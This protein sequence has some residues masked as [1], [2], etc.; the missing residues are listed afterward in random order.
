MAKPR[1]NFDAALINDLRSRVI[2]HNTRSGV[3]PVKLG[4]L[5]HVYA[6]SYSGA[7]AGAAAMGAVEGFLAKAAGD[8][9][10]AEH[11]R[12]NDGKFAGRG[13]RASARINTTFP[14][15]HDDHTALAASNAGYRALQSG[16]IPENRGETTGAIARQLGSG[17]AGLT[18]AV[19]LARGKPNGIAASLL[20]RKLAP[21]G[22]LAGAAIGTAAGIVEQR[23]GDLIHKIPGMAETSAD[24]AARTA[25]AN[26][27]SLQASIVGAK[28]ARRVGITTYRVASSGMRHWMDIASVGASTPLR[29]R[30]RRVGAV[31]LAA[32]PVVSLINHE[33][34]GSQVDPERLGSAF[35]AY[36]VRHVLKSVMTD[37]IGTA[38]NDLVDLLRKGISADELFKAVPALSG[39]Y[40]AAG[41]AV[42]TGLGA[43]SGGLAGAGLGHGTQVVARHIAGKRGNPYHDGR[44]RFTHA[45]GAGALAGGVA[46]AVAAGLA[47]YAGLRTH[48]IGQLRA[49]AK[50]AL[51]IN[52]RRMAALSNPKG[53]G[54][55]FQKLLAQRTNMIDEAVAAHPSVKAAKDSVEQFG[56]SS[57]LHYKT[58]ILRHSNERIAS[59]A[60]FL[61]NFEVPVTKSGQTT[62]RRIADIKAGASR[63]ERDQKAAD[64]IIDFVET[65]SPADFAR[66]IK[67]VSVENQTTLR[68]F[69]DNQTTW[70]NG[71]DQ[72]IAAHHA[73]IAAAQQN[74]EA[75]ATAHLAA[76]A[77]ELDA[78]AV[79]GRTTKEDE[80]AVKKTEAAMAK[81]GKES[82]KARKAHEKAV[83][84]LD[85]LKNGS[86]K[87]IS[88]ITG[89]PLAQPTPMDTRA[90]IQNAEN[91]V[92]AV[93][94]RKVD[95]EIAAFRT[96][97]RRAAVERHNRILAA[98]AVIGD[99]HGLPEAARSRGAVVA[100][101]ERQIRQ[102]RARV[103]DA[104]NALD[105]AQAAL[106]GIGKRPKAD[107]LKQLRNVVQA[108]A[109]RVAGAQADL[110]VSKSRIAPLTANFVKHLEDRAAGNTNRLIPAGL[111]GD[112]IRDLG[113]ATATMKGAARDFLAQPTM[114]GLLNFAASTYRTVHNAVTDTAHQLFFQETS[115]GWKPSWVRI[116]TSSALV[117]PTI[118]G[119]KDLYD[120]GRAAIAGDPAAKFPHHIIEYD[121]DPNTGAAYAAVVVPHPK[122]KGEKVVL[123]GQR[124]DSFNGQARQI[125]AGGRISTVKENYKKRNDKNNDAGDATGRVHNGDADAMSDETKKAIGESLGKLRGANSIIYADITN[126]PRVAY[127]SSKDQD[128]NESAG[129][130]LQYMRDRFLNKGSLDQGQYWKALTALSSKQA[131]IFSPKQS[132]EA[133]TNTKPDGGEGRYKNG[134]FTQASGFGST[135]HGVVLAALRSEV[136]RAMKQNPNAEQKDALQRAV[137]LV[138]VAKGIDKGSK[139]DELRDLHVKLRGESNGGRQQS[140]ANAGPGMKDTADEAAPQPP[141]W[142]KED[143]RNLARGAAI[144]L[145]KQLRLF[146]K[147]SQEE[148]TSAIVVLARKVHADHGLS[149]ADSVRAVQGGLNAI[150]G[151]NENAKADLADQMA[152][153]YWQKSPDL[154]DAID[155]AA[156]KLKKSAPLYSLDELMKAFG[157]F[158]GSKHPRVSQ[159]QHGGGE[160]ASEGSAPAAPSPG[161]GSPD[162]GVDDPS[163]APGGAAQARPRSLS[164]I[165]PV[166]AV[167]ELASALGMQAGWELAQHHL[168]G[169]GA[170]LAIS[171]AVAGAA[172][173]SESLA[174]GL[175]QRFLPPV[176]GAGVQALRFGGA[177]VAGGIAGAAAEAAGGAAVSGAYRAAG[178]QA[179]EHRETPNPIGRTAAGFVGTLAGGIGGA[180]L[181]SGVASIATGAVGQW[182]GN[183]AG[184]QVYDAGARIAGWLSGYGAKNSQRVIQKYMQPAK[185]A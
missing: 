98:L 143:L 184:E 182:A 163:A 168:P 153:G 62:R 173:G 29:A 76:Q 7:N 75:A 176:A 71:V 178:A 99:A 174:W 14:A 27:R 161:S 17:V 180:A 138:A 164:P 103:A 83:A 157:A 3:S 4:Q 12:D 156:R 50:M 44:G 169:A 125:Y 149:M 132:F 162:D 22:S 145:N 11:P 131:A 16:V 21:V 58:A 33:I 35:D 72:Q 91:K 73:S 42:L 84:D 51:A 89:Q 151:A 74:V 61:D 120:Y 97:Q 130:F 142:N 28:I 177:L 60:A 111:R 8:F 185:S 160:F 129:K 57:P 175:A 45:S 96:A 59:I 105:S 67:N 170:R 19:S 18:L 52:E 77:N 32:I 23:V 171:D 144:A 147:D 24:Q 69:F 9:D 34:A 68:H 26:S 135:E 133:L 95:A 40:S 154:F 2:A 36:S 146:H 53:F 155:E 109:D 139:Q 126:G 118:V 85:S 148:T 15:S 104:S 38:R 112:I 158:D 10:D 55:D 141:D 92:F 123:Y 94:A 108:A 165:H 127:R 63:G 167:P 87:I 106:A 166:R 128:G 79:L 172:K 117:G 81:A 101:L 159:G 136:D 181:G 122:E 1:P 93:A 39:G 100:R 88:P 31:G 47:T 80:G 183:I 137:H 90:T 70:A 65:A 54:K 48:N 46:G 107:Q 49:A 152:G 114:V 5:R 134:I 82:E 56:P 86:P 121:I 6:K 110:A 140:K 115:Q 43:A 41:R 78:K 13:G 66:A 150:S 20:R 37:E 179:P 102:H 124:Q 116:A 119:A 25:A 30:A 64:L 113:L